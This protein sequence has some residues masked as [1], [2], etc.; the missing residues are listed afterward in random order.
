MNNEAK[1]LYIGID[2]AKQDLVF[3][4]DGQNKSHTV[5]NKPHGHQGIIEHIHSLERSC[6][7]VLESTGGYE[8]AL[9]E[10]LLEAGIEAAVVLPQ[11]VRDYARSQGHLAKTDAIDAA[12]IAEFARISQPRRFQRQDQLHHE[13]KAFYQRR[14]DLIKEQT[15]EHNRLDTAPKRLCELIHGHLQYLNEQIAQIEQQVEALIASSA[16]MQIKEQRLREIQSIGPVV[17]RTLLI[18]MPELGTLSDTQAAALAGVAPYNRDSGKSSKPARTHGGRAK[19][20]SML[21]MAAVV[22]SRCNPVLSPFYKRLIA[23]GKP[24]KVALTAVM[25]KLIIIANHMLKYPDFTLA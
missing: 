16:Q 5:P 2:I 10:A 24:P 12:V 8:Y 7:A 1:I 21:Y 22:A 3:V 15:R 20:R 19:V 25:R 11:R 13:L 18:W 4:V 9:L 6:C 14:A 23:R 17:S